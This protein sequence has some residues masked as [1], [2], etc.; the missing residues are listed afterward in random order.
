MATTK[1][2]LQQRIADLERELK[3]KDRRIE[4]LKLELDEQRELVREM[5]EHVKED[6]EYLE[7]FIQTFGLVLNDNGEWTNGE[8]NA[9]HNA[10]VEKHND[11]R[12]RYNKLVGRF[13]RNIASVNP[14][15]RPLAAS[16]EQ[17]AQIVRHHKAGKSSRWIAEELNLSR[18]TVTTVTG[19]LDGT[20]RTTA[21]RRLKLGLEP[22]IKDW[23]VASRERLPKAATKH[24]EKGRKLLKE[25]KGL[26]PKG[27][28]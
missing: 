20:D 28:S 5:E 4:E 12:G 3:F 18:R 19:K 14:V 15:G 8:A 9:E 10:L 13:N 2:D 27:A 7:D 21:L 16:E 11:L 22:K 26:A 17:Q 24:F 6:A 23:R 1:T 25:A